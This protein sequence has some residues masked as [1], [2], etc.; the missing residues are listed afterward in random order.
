MG[1]EM[2]ESQIFLMLQARDSEKTV[3]GRFMA[4]TDVHVNRHRMLRTCQHVTSHGKRDFIDGIKDL[5]M[6]GK[7]ILGYLGRLNVISTILIIGKQEHE[8]EMW[9]QKERSRR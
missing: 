4:P 6:V 7:M 2:E 1:M 3:V 8:S 9:Q 5:K